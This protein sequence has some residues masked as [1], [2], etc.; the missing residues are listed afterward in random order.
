MKNKNILYEIIGWYGTLAI[1]LAYAGN[2]FN[3]ITSNSL[4]YQL[5]NF[6]GAIGIITISLHKKVYQ[7]VAL[8][9]VWG[10]VAIIAIAGMVVR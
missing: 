8:N 1:I 4:A 10:V 2:S 5:L 9:I 7:S 3:L 6:T